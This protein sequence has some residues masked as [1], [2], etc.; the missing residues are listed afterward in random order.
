L[1]LL[2]T[3]CRAEDDF[4]GSVPPI[5]LSDPVDLPNLVCAM[6]YSMD[7]TRKFLQMGY[8]RSTRYALRPA[9]RKYS[10]STGLE[11]PR[12]GEIADEEKYRGAKVFKEVWKRLEAD[13]KYEQGKERWRVEV[14]GKKPATTNKAVKVEVE[15]KSEQGKA[16]SKPSRAAADRLSGKHEE[17]T[18]VR[19]Q[20]PETEP[21][22]EPLR[23][24][25]QEPVESEEEEKEDIKPAKQRKATRSSAEVSPSRAKR[26]TAGIGRGTRSKGPVKSEPDE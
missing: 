14:E 2:G 3:F 23:S 10:A 8:T 6:I 7:I 20:R 1:R 11:I 5:S 13:P 22:P 17:E 24:I 19:N 18:P 9:G 26:H 25:K 4:V 12:T 16:A 15:E 21:E